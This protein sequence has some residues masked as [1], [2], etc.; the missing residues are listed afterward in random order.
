M[1]PSSVADEATSSFCGSSGQVFFRSHPLFQPDG[2]RMTLCI[3]LHCTSS[4]TRQA[5]FWTTL[6]SWLPSIDLYVAGFSCK[7]FSMLHNNT[8]LLEEPE[9]KIFFAV[10]DRI[11]NLQ[12]PCFVLE[13]VTGIKRCLREV[14]DMLEALGYIIIVNELNPLDLGEPVSRPRMY[15]IGI[16]RQLARASQADC[17]AMYE[18]VWTAL[19]GSSGPMVPLQQRLLSHN[20]CWVAN[21]QKVRLDRWEAAKMRGFPDGTSRETKWRDQHAAWA[22]L[23]GLDTDKRTSVKGL[24]P[25][26]LY[27]HLPRERDAWANLMQICSKPR[28][29]VADIS[30]SMARIKVCD[31]F[32][33]TITPGGHVIVAQ[34]K[35]SMAPMEKLLIH[36]LPLHRMALPSSISDAEWESMGGNMMH[37]QTV[38]VA[39]MLAL[40]LVDWSVPEASRRPTKQPT[41]SS[42]K[43]LAQFQRSMAPKGSAATRR[44][45]ASLRARFGLINKGTSKRARYSKMAKGQKSK[46][47]KTSRGSHPKHVAC[48]CG[49]RWASW[50]A[51]F[52]AIYY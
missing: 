9:A 46:P 22:E 45:E 42:Q 51:V 43:G 38:G 48:L 8:K 24:M 3:R 19:K 33:P 34:F 4:N 36:G 47:R 29:A 6:P 18:R 37:L 10:L 25:D 30:Q 44:L 14:T 13:N 16:R 28:C 39:M 50:M 1:I 49:T 35:R 52:F 26:D 31:S 27:L 32:L 17:Q 7:P 41:L 21:S 40:V 23:Q 11:K 20:H 12:P 5:R 2:V 15:F